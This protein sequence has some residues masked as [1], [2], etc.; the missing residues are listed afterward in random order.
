ML[1]ASCHTSFALFAEFA[2]LPSNH[3]RRTILRIVRILRMKI[4]TCTGGLSRCPEQPSSF[5]APPLYPSFFLA[6]DE[7]GVPEGTQIAGS[8]RCFGLLPG[9]GGKQLEVQEA[10]YQFPLPTFRC[11]PGEA[12]LARVGCA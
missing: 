3:C 7:L 1:L 6:A 11:L 5:E 9:P 10:P 12:V 2:E 8:G 4:A